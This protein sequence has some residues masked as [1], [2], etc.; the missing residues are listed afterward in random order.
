MK[1]LEKFDFQDFFEPGLRFAHID[2]LFMV[3]M[4]NKRA[5]GAYYAQKEMSLGSI[6]N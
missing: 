4:G 3:V 2:L 5:T 6:I 1:R